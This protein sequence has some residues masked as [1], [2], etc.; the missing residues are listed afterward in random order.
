MVPP[1]PHLQE[2]FDLKEVEEKVDEPR[3]MSTEVEDESMSEDSDE[4][5]DDRPVGEKKLKVYRK[6]PPR[7]HGEEAHSHRWEPPQGL[8]APSS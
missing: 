5:P 6:N 4:D 8:A 3:P 7:A 2:Y 1:F